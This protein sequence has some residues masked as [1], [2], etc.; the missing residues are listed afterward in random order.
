M[1]KRDEKFKPTNVSETCRLRNGGCRCLD[2]GYLTIDM[3]KGWKLYDRK[4][5]LRQQAKGKYNAGDHVA[6][7]M[8]A[9]RNDRRP[10]ADIEIGHL[11]ATLAHLSNI[12][13]RTGRREL[14]F[15]PR[16]EQIIDAPQANALMQRTYRDGYWAVPKDA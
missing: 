9:I 1:K 7:F 4:N 11:S 16:T 12:V 6:D 10:N 15:D 13:G 14:T 2:L 5:V 8:D 3:Q